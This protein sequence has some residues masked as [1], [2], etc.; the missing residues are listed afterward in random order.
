MDKNEALNWRICILSVLLVALSG[1][2]SCVHLDRIGTQA[3][4]DMV[5]NGAHPIA[6][7]CAVWDI[8]RK[9][10]LCSLTLP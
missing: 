2:G 7:R 1:V 6:A 5:E 9:E 8:H 4:V 10:V 3:I